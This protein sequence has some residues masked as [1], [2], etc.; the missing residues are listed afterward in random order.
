MFKG[1]AA[2]LTINSMIYGIGNDICD[3]RCIRASVHERGGQGGEDLHG[4]ILNG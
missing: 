1:L 4:Y 2:D 3:V